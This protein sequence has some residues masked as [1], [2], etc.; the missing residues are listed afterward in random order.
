MVPT[1]QLGR[2]VVVKKFLILDNEREVVDRM[3][4]WELRALRM[5]AKGEIGGDLVGVVVCGRSIC[6]QFV[7]WNDVCRKTRQA[8]WFVRSGFDLR[9]VSMN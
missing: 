3:E 7:C 6:V 8:T 5:R 1:E 4:C 2:V 9:T